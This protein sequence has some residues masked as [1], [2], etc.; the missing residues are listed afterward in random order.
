MP[1]ASF[2]ATGTACGRLRSL[3][4]REVFPF[5]QAPIPS[6]ARFYLEDGQ[7]GNTVAFPVAIVPRGMFA[8]QATTDCAFPAKRQAVG[9]ET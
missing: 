7:Y 6:P 8:K 9:F 2:V 1:V 4:A 5:P 3:L